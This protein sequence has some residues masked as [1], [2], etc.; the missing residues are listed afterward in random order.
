MISFFSVLTYI[1]T[2]FICFTDKLYSFC[3]SLFFFYCTTYMFYPIITGYAVNSLTAKQKGTGYSFTTLIV[4]FCGNF[5]GPLYYGIINHKFKSTNPRLA[6]RSSFFYYIVGFTLL[7]F[8][9]YFRYK[10]LAKKEVENNTKDE[11]EMKEI[12]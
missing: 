7:Q 1:T 2:F 11:K 6:W 8:A 5:P 12:E 4:T 9:C 10:D 3:I